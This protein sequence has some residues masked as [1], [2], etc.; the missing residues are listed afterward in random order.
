MKLINKLRPADD[1]SFEVERIHLFN[2]RTSIRYLKMSFR[3]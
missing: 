3:R 1:C 2:F